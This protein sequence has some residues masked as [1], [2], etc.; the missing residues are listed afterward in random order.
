MLIISVVLVAIGGI[1]SLSVRSGNGFSI[2]HTR[3]AG[4]NGIMRGRADLHFLLPADRTN[5]PRSLH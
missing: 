5:L 1:L 3:F 2:E 4:S